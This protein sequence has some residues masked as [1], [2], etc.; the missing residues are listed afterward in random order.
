MITRIV[1][2]VKN[3]KLTIVLLLVAVYLGIKPVSSFLG[4]NSYQSRLTPSMGSASMPA[5]VQYGADVSGKAMFGGVSA[6]QTNS[7]APTPEITNRMVIQNSNMSLLVKDVV[8]VRK[9]IIGFAESNGGYMVDSVT[10]NPQDAPTSTVTVRLPSDKLDQALD[11]FR[12]LSIKVVSENL[13]GRDVTDQYVDIDARVETLERTKGKMES[14]LAQASQISDLTTV[15]REIISLQ[16]QIDAL[17][18]A[19]KSLSENAKMAKVTVY[20]STDEIALPYAPSETFRPGVIFKLAVRSMVSHLRSVASLVIW[21]VVYSV[22]WIP[23]LVVGYFLNRK[24]KKQ[25]LN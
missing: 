19:Q 15:T 21:V 3:H 16:N 18:G 20:L 7:Y 22:I 25:N 2:W 14:I 13:V 17:K 9:K 5:D 23:V 8:D 1:D 24:F 11:L 6:L 12:G 4:I 10:S